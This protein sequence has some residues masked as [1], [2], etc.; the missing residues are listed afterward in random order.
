MTIFAGEMPNYTSHLKDPI[1]K[2]IAEAGEELNQATY[3][4][5]LKHKWNNVF[6][7][8]KILFFETVHHDRK[9]QFTL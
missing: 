9:F 3:V 7:F 6:N 1:F 5:P 2:I 8:T 4:V